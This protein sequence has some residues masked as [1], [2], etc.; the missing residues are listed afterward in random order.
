MYTAIYLKKLPKIPKDIIN[1]SLDMDNFFYGGKPSRILTKNKKNFSAGLNRRQELNK[2]LENWLRKNIICDWQDAGYSRTTGPCHGPHIDRARFFT[3]QYVIDPG[4]QNVSTVFYRAKTQKLDIEPGWFYIN[5]YDEIEPI[6][7][8]F[9]PKD[10]WVLINARNHIHSVENIE[11]VRV[12]VQ[13]GLMK[14]PMEDILSL[15][16]RN[17]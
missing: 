8:Q 13:I 4:G 17:Y 15:Q 6:E 9:I 14:D 11:G 10:V 5:N 7:H 1:Y 16:T 3:L 2:E 12:S